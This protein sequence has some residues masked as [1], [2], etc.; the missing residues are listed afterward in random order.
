[1]SG[2]GRVLAPL[3]LLPRDLP[4][5]GGG[6][7][8]LPPPVR[9]QNLSP[10]RYFQVISNVRPVHTTLG[11]PSPPLRG[12]T[13]PSI[14]N[15]RSRVRFSRGT[16]RNHRNLEVLGLIPP[17]GAHLLSL[18]VSCSSVPPYR[19]VTPKLLTRLP[20]VLGGQTVNSAPSSRPSE[21]RSHLTLYERCGLFVRH[22][23]NA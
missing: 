1:M 2:R 16:N 20:L 9:C 12:L 11:R 17:K 10:R 18:P 21:T 5:H 23:T 4:P 14:P 13:P 19:P 7:R 6:W 8:D 3:S 22:S 15:L